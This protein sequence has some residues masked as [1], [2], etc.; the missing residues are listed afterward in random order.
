MSVV[1]TV[2]FATD[3]YKDAERFEEL[4]AQLYTRYSHLGPYKVHRAEQDGPKYGPGDVYFYGFNYMDSEL[5]N[6]LTSEPWHPGTILW[7]LDEDD[8]PIIYTGGS[9][10]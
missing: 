7:M 10:F 6:A 4:V 3:H 9:E 8:D 1:T 5:K 2:V